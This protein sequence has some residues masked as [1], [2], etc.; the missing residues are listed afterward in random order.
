MNY[1]LNGDQCIYTGMKS[2]AQLHK[3]IWPG[4]QQVHTDIICSGGDF[5]AKR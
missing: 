3:N 5:Q 1:S 4:N 2:C